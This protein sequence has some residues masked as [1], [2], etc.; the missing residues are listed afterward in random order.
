MPQ[1]TSGS[2]ATP[3]IANIQD[4]TTIHVEARSDPANAIWEVRISD[5]GPGVPPELVE[6]IFLP[7]FTTKRDGNGIGLAVTMQVARAHGG[8]V[9]VEPASPRS[10]DSS[11]S[12]SMSGARFVVQL[13]L[14]V[15]NTPPS[16]A[17]SGGAGASFAQD[18]DH[19]GRGEPEVLHTASAR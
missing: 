10:A 17:H 1:G 6:K 14:S 9:F 2:N 16:A 3:G 15:G 7:Y 5:Q 18:P 8:R 4:G 13:P 19:R 11:T 12:S